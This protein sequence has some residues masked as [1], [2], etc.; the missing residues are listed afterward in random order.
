M[1]LGGASRIDRVRSMK[2]EVVQISLDE[3]T[4]LQAADIL[5]L[6]E[7]LWERVDI[8]GSWEQ[9]LAT[10]KPFSPAQR[11]LFAIQWYRCE[12]DNGG[13]CQFFSNSTGIVWEHAV[14]GFAAIGLPEGAA[15]LQAASDRV[16]GASRDR[17]KREAQLDSVGEDFDDLDE[18]FYAMDET[19][20]IDEKMLRFARA[21]A[22]EFRF[23]GTVERVII[24]AIRPDGQ[25]K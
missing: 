19:G 25:P 17:I 23:D 24:D 18:R 4:V 11:H 2:T 7:P 10:L 12:V 21:H 14:E 6:V 8:Y 13:H 9:Y 16:G 15:I 5:S 3:E 22:A 20:A 1:I